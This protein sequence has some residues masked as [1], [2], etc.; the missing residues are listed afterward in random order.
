MTVKRRQDL[1]ETDRG[2]YHNKEEWLE[3]QKQSPE[4]FCEKKCS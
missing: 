2:S 1:A 4:V 3:F